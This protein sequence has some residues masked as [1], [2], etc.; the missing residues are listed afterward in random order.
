MLLAGGFVFL[1]LK[2]WKE[3]RPSDLLCLVWG[4]LILVLSIQ[5]AGTS[6]LLAAPFAVISGFFVSSAIDYGK[7]ASV[8]LSTERLPEKLLTRKSGRKAKKTKTTGPR[9]TGQKNEWKEL[10]VIGAI[11][12]SAGFIGAS[13]WSDLHKQPVKPQEGWIDALEWLGSN[14]PDPGIDY[15]K[16]YPGVG[17]KYPGEAYGVMS[18]WD[19]GHMITYFAHRIPNTNP[20]PVRGA[21]RFRWCGV[22]YVRE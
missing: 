4:V 9:R 20:L 19:Y 8:E 6:T 2:V 3:K 10:L 16:N 21:G 15:Y 18:W 17:F 22:L 1:F 7:P 11:I 5:H 12:F 14:S 13:L